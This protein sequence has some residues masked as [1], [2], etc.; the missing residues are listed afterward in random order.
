MADGR[1]GATFYQSST[2]WTDV[3]SPLAYNDGTWHHVAAILK[4]GFAQI[5]VDG[6]LVAQDTTRPII[7]VQASTQTS[8]GQ[9]ASGFA[10]SIDELFIYG[11]ALSDQEIAA[12]AT[13]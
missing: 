12:L 11:R 8:V 3:V 7:S 13:G 2:A 10:G 9:V 5:Y 4:N 1:F 6:V